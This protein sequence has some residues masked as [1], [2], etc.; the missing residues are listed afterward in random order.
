MTW[1]STAPVGQRGSRK[2]GFKTP[3]A[4]RFWQKVDKRGPDECWLWLGA[5]VRGGYGQSYLDG[6]KI[7]AHRVSLILDER[8]PGKLDALHS[9][10][11]P[12]CVNPAH[13]RPGTEKENAKDA[14]DAGRFVFSKP[15]EDHPRS[16]LTDS[17]VREIRVKHANGRSFHS[18]AR[19]Y[20]V[21]R[22]TIKRCVSG[23]TWGHVI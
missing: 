18:L 20:G 8:D 5:K 16:K 15:G 2:Y 23:E 3:I 9:C 11:N 6:K 14:I 1:Q 22:P 12:S 4:D 17:I 7:Y 21:A 13:L 19:E 10:H